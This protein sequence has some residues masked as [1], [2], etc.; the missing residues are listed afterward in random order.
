LILQT[1]YIVKL[2]ID[3]VRPKMRPGGSIDEL[4]RDPYS[5]CC[6]A[7]ASFQPIAYPKLAPNLLHV[8]RA[9]LVGE[10]GVPSDDEQ[11]LEVR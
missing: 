3:S 7:N 6:F 1:E 5:V 2:T 8:D 9:P 4:S 10:A 11:R